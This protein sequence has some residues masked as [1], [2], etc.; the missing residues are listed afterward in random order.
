VIPSSPGH[1]Y[2]FLASLV[3]VYIESGISR[4]SE[5]ILESIRNVQNAL[6]K[7]N[8]LNDRIGGSIRSALSNSEK[9]SSEISRIE[10]ELNKIQQP[11]IE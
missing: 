2:G 6:D 7:L 5:K 9:A 8:S 4:D 3:A 1:L 11:E 10:I